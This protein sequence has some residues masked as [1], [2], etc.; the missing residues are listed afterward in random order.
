MFIGEIKTKHGVITR[1]K[2]D[3]FRFESTEMFLMVHNT[4]VRHVFKLVVGIWSN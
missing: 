3:D 1:R 2:L 4:T